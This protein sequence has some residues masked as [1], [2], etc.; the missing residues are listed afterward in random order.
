MLD[1]TIG[2]Q[3][4]HCDFINNYAKADS[5][6]TGGLWFGLLPEVLLFTTSTNQFHNILRDLWRFSEP[7]GLIGPA[8]PWATTLTL[9]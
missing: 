7:K 6:S 3:K 9:P 8:K 1:R 4:R 5:L 2:E